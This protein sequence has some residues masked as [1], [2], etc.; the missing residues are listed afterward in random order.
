MR[1]CESDQYFSIWVEWYKEKYTSPSQDSAYTPYSTN[2]HYPSTSCHGFQNYLTFLIAY[3]LISEINCLVS[4]T[5]NLPS[6]VLL[7]QT[8]TGRNGGIFVSG[9]ISLL[10]LNSFYNIIGNTWQWHNMA[11][12][13]ASQS[14]RICLIRQPHHLLMLIFERFLRTTSLQEKSK[15]FQALSTT[16]LFIQRQLGIQKIQ[17]MRPCVLVV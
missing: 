17:I 15:W 6:I 9:F 16:P 11:L 13:R 2:Q 1:R 5:L 14:S 3:R 8:L 12:A 7:H 4:A 10:F